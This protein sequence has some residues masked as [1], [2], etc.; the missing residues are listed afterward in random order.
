MPFNGSGVYS[1]PSTTVTPAVT[2]TTIDASEFNT[3][4]ADLVNSFNKCV[5]N[6]ETSSPTLLNPIIN[7]AILDTNSNELV[8]FVTTASA[9][10]N[11]RVTNATTGNAAKID[12]SET[13][14]PIEIAGNGTGRVNI[15]SDVYLDRTSSDRNIIFGDGAGNDVYFYGQ[16]TATSY[17]VGMFDSKNSLSVWNYDESTYALVIAATLTATNAALTTPTITTPAITT[18]TVNGKSG[19]GMVILDEPVSLVSSS[20]ATGAWTQLDMSAVYAQAA[21][22]SAV[23]AILKCY[24][25]VEADGIDRV[26]QIFL[27]KTGTSTGITTQARAVR[28]IGSESGDTSVETNTTMVNLDSNSDFDYYTTSTGSA[29]NFVIDLVG[30]YV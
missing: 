8:N 24:C 12:V 4:T 16:T 2:G 29:G 19:Y 21:T 30:Y 14:A 7:S 28:V 9:V 11:V 20:T 6:N 27:R 10:N 17:D 22:D 23:I 25:L 26:A 3:F 15:G 18:P 1:L 13:N 5:V